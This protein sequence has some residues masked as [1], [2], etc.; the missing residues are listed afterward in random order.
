MSY[1]VIQVIAPVRHHKLLESM[2]DKSDVVDAWKNHEGSDR[3]SYSF[4]VQSDKS[5]SVIDALQTTMGY[6][7]NARVLVLPVEAMLPKNEDAAEKPTQKGKKKPSGI[8]R[9][10]LYDDV[11][12]GAKCDTNFILFAVLSTI[13][14]AIGL[15]QNNVAVVIGAMVIAPFLGPNLALALATSLGDIPLIKQAIKTNLT[16][17]AITL[18]LCIAL[19]KFFPPAPLSE[20]LLNRT[21][22]DFDGIVL[23]LA[24]GAA[25]VLSLTT[26]ISS[27]LVGV[28]VAVALLPPAATLGI[29]L[30]M[31]SVELAY[32]AALVLAVNVV[33][34][35][36]SAKVVLW[37]KGIVLVPAASKNLLNEQCYG[38]YPYG[39]WG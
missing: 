29:L 26:G 19:G 24:S 28:M 32:V 37:L 25:G 5:Q 7:D 3:L 13:V 11:V 18:F 31:G 1:R 17:L 2:C 22:I 12:K 10:E 33:C 20:E 27:A 38:L 15:M 23:A 34:V 16:G 8:S 4:L 9:E 14:A 21:R 39:Y 36:L 35:N 6:S 30:G